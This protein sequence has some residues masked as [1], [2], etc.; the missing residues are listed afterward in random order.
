MTIALL[1][2]SGLLAGTEIIAMTL[3]TICSRKKNLLYMTIAILLYGMVIPFLVY[4][5]LSYSS[6]GTVNFT[7][8][9]ITTISMIIIGKLLFND[10]ITR[11]HLV[12]FLM[13]ITS[14]AILYIAE[15][16]LIKLH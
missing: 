4:Y 2:M 1:S 9:I 12:S 10:I 3:I 8:N 13:G 7:W 16:D 14:M 11:L 5:S 6:I 15:A